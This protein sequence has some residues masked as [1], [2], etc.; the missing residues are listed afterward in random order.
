MY[1]VIYP[2]FAGGGGGTSC[3]PVAGC[4]SRESSLDISY[5]Y[6]QKGAP[7]LYSHIYIS[8]PLPPRPLSIW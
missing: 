6:T 5:I 3:L 8:A 1:T 4:P 2:R 7:L